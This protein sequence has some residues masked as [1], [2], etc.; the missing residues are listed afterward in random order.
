[1]MTLSRILRQFD[2]ETPDRIAIHLLEARSDRSMT[3]RELI[4]GAAGYSQILRGSGIGNGEVVIIILQHG[5]DLIHAF[6]GAILG[7]MVPSIMPF[8]TEKLPPEAYRRSLA[9]LIQV[10]E[11]AAI[12]TYPEFLPEVEKA[13]HEGDSVRVVIHSGQVPMLNEVDMDALPGMRCDPDEIVLLQHSSG[14]TGLQKGVALSH[15]AVIQQVESYADAIRM[16]PADKVVSWLPL[17]H[18]MGLIAGFIMPILLGAPLILMSP[19][20]WVRAPYKLMRA[21]Y[22]GC[23]ISPTTSAHRRFERAIWRGW[24]Y[25]VG[26]RSSIAR[27]RCVGKAIGCFW[28]G[29]S[30]MDSIRMPWRLAM[31]WP[32][33]FS[34]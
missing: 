15:Q 11:P 8:L 23:P 34:R 13:T 2:H 6:W 33:T 27:S 9:S 25:P 28:T 29:S 7:G 20:D 26:G 19:F 31:P 30:P 18:D 32:R 21:R 14:T 5:A 17:Y 4:L 3:Y 10:T 16:T 24:T 1:M 12:I 22:H